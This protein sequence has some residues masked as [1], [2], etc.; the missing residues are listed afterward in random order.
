MKKHLYLTA[1]NHRFKNEKRCLIDKS[2]KN[3][4]RINLHVVVY[5]IM[6]FILKFILIKLH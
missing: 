4:E 1:I 2:Y 5:K 3:L 6:I